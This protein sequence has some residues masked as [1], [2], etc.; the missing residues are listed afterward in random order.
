MDG[1]R[2]LKRALELEFKGR[3][4]MG[5]SRTKWFSQVLED[6][7]KRGNEEELTVN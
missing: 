3:R 2:I 6:I 1:T 5:Q 4:P 7:K